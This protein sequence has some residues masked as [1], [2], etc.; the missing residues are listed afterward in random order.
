MLKKIHM[1]AKDWVM[2]HE[3]KLRLKNR[4]ELVKKLTMCRKCYTFYYNN[5]W[6]FEKPEYLSTEHEEEVPVRFTECSACMEQDLASYEIESNLA[7][8]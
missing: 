4:Q 3:K 8:S 6:H 5:A 1:S 2:N 7:W